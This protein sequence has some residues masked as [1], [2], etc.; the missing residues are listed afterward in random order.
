MAVKSVCVCVA[1]I[2]L[3]NVDEQRSK[4]HDLVMSISEPLQANTLLKL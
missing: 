1:N 4:V 3:Y 2:F